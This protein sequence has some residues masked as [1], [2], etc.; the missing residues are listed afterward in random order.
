M[1]RKELKNVY[2][3]YNKAMWLVRLQVV[4]FFLFASVPFFPLQ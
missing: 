2:K 1:Q 4:V 3:N